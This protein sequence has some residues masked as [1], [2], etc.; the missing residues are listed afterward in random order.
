[1]KKSPHLSGFRIGLF[2][3][4]IS[5]VIFY[6]GI[7]FLELVELKAY[8]LHFSAKSKSEVGTEVVI[9]TVDE[10]SIDKL[11]RWPWPRSTM[12]ELLDSLKSYGASVVAFDIVFSEPDN[13]SG[14][15]YYEE[16]KDTLVTRGFDV[17]PI[18][19]KLKVERDNDALFASAIKDNPAV[20]LGYYFYTTAGEIAHRRDDAGE[21]EI[22]PKSISKLSDIDGRAIEPD[23]LSTVGIEENINATLKEGDPGSAF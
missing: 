7:P 10:K 19:E 15:A 8:D 20:I 6:I 21:A 9:V 13:T 22:F 1:M 3:T 16:L 18:I 17:A 12:A 11:G 14:A 23:I 4:L 5:I 2:L